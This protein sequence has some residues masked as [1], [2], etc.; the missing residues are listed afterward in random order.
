VTARKD[1]V[2]PVFEAVRLVPL[3]AVGGEDLATA[4]YDWVQHVRHHLI[5]ADGY[6]AKGPRT[7][8]ACGYCRQLV[9]WERPEFRRAG[10][11]WIRL[12]SKTCVRGTGGSSGH[13]GTS[14]GH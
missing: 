12:H 7:G 11:E 14:H 5:D 1:F 2:L 10:V 6:L 8:G 13:G 3:D 9:T 4:D